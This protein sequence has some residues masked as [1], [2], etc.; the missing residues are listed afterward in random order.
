VNLAIDEQHGNLFCVAFAKLVI[1]VDVVLDE[2]YLNVACDTGVLGTK[3]A[4]HG[5]YHHARLVTEV[6]TGFSDQSELN[7]LRHLNILWRL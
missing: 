7:A 6:T 3:V 5:V 2:V 4:N 1:E